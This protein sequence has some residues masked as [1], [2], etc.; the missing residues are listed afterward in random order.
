VT[1]ERI[2]DI[3]PTSLHQRSTLVTGSK[4]EVEFFLEYTKQFRK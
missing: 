4:K 1:G 3:V 2:L